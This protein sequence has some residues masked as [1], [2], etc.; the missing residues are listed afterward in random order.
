MDNENHRNVLM[1]LKMDTHRVYN[2]IKIRSPEYITLL[3]LKRSRAH[4]PKIFKNK[5]E[6]ISVSEL[7]YCSE[8]VLVS[9]DQFYHFVD[10]MSWYFTHTED[11]PTKMED[12]VKFLLKE[13]DKHYAML[14]ILLEAELEI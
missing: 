9:L 12:T 5:Y 14:N 2:R 1:I 4:F 6:S 11:L 13:I 10:E 3:T 8:E 7:K